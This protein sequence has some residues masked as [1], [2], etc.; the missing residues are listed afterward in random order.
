MLGTAEWDAQIATNQH[1]VV[2]ELAREFETYF[3]ES[4]GLR[5]VR[6]DARDLRRIAGRLRKSVMGQIE[7]AHRPVPERARII[8]PLILPLHRT[9]TRY[10]NRAL[11]ERAVAQWRRSDGPRILW[12]FTPVTYDLEQY[13]DFTVYQCVDILRAFPGIDAAA[14][15]GGERNLTK[16]ADLTIATSHAVATHLNQAGFRQVVTLPNV[17][18]VDVFSSRRSPTAQRRPAAIFAGNLSPH[19]LDFP[20]LCDLAKALQGHGELLLAGPLAAGGGEFTR[21]LTTLER[22]GARYLGALSIPELADIAG[23]CT[24]GLIPYALNEYT[25][26]VSPLK[27]YEYLSAGLNVVSTAV[28]DVVRAAEETNFIEVAQSAEDFVQRVLRTIA[29]ASDTTIG[30]RSAYAQGFGW[31]AR[32]GLFRGIVARAGDSTA[33]D[34]DL[35]EEIRSF[36]APIG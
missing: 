12:T 19:K 20:L 22:L 1:Y 24:V 10:L 27:C 35:A 15:D 6:L 17:A 3:V 13:A 31:E 9:Q 28:P 32:G 23:T 25:A 36:G 2:R 14:V 34:M 4:L 5:R 21:E 30:A 26:G 8:A 29:P 7:L 33:P 18:D 16:R 11:L